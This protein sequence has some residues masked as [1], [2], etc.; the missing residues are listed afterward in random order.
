MRR[1]YL[2]AASAFAASAAT[3]AAAQDPA[4]PQTLTM[5][6]AAPGGSYAAYGPAW[7]RI[8]QEAT[9]V[10]IAY[11]S[12]QGPAQ[13]VALVNR[14]EIDLG[15]ATLGVALQGWNGQGDWTQGR[16][17]RE[18]RALFPMYDTPFH[19]IA[20]R[21]SGIAGHAQLTGR[22]VGV[23]PRGGT[24]GSYYPQMLNALG[25]RPSS[26]R[27]GSA[28]DLVGQ[29]QDGLLD[30]C[31][32]AAGAPVPAFAEAEAQAELTFLDFTAEE[33]RRLAAQFPELTPAKLPLGVYR[34][35]TRP[36][37]LVGMFNFA[38]THRSLPEALGYA[39]TRA[40]LGEN[41]RF[42]QAVQA[43]SETQAANW[44]A[45]SILPFHPGAARY[46]REVGQPVPDRLIGS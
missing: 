7:G 11:R 22:S 23:G 12:T 8:V 18:I 13:N 33:V 17:H 5:G 21:R 1:R 42:R 32:L 43:A 40:V 6:T 36:L 9:G 35:Q 19:G 10:R 45:N 41:A 44:A 46:L 24:S 28:A 39:I 37:N 14:C 27:H 2:L 15:M 20:L 16:P 34:Q 3:R 4:W 29:V 38:I 26:L 31:L 25:I 30:A